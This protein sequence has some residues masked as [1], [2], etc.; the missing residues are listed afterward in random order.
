M[1]L[2]FLQLF[3]DCVGKEGGIKS[4]S[5]KY[6]SVIGTSIFILNFCI[7]LILF[8]KLRRKKQRKILNFSC[9]YEI[10]NNVSIVILERLLIGPNERLD[11]RVID[12]KLIHNNRN[13]VILF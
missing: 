13:I 12:E 9:S 5:R 10:G 3:I 4:C 6:E 8:L 1:V 11:G 7:F 2:H